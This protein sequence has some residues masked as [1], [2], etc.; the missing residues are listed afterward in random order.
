MQSTKQQLQTS[1]LTLSVILFWAVVGKLGQ[2]G[3][4]VEQFLGKLPPPPLEETLAG[5]DY[6]ALSKSI[7]CS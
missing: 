6:V 7:I 1:C 3:G 4:E 2:F 5:E